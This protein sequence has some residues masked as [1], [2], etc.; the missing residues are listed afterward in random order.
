M[1]LVPAAAAGSVQSEIAIATELARQTP[2]I[3]DLFSLTT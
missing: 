3:A 1:R 2:C